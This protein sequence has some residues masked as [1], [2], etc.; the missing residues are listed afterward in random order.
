MTKVLVAW[1]LLSV[2]FGVLVAA[3]LRGR[4]PWER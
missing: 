2:P 1:V 3:M 4:W